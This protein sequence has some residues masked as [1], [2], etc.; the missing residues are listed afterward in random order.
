MS[1]I[2]SSDAELIEKIRLRYKK[3]AQIAIEN[4][5]QRGLNEGKLEAE[6]RVKEI[7]EECKKWKAIADSIKP[8]SS[9]GKHI[10]LVKFLMEQVVLTK[11]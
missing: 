5:Y 3:E 9:E 2:V 10:S 4:A 6:E 7:E 1:D 11:S 8:S